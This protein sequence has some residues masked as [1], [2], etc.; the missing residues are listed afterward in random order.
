MLNRLET[1]RGRNPELG[2]TAVE[3]ALMVTMIAAVIIG[4]VAMI[5]TNLIPIFRNA[6]SSI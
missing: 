6:S 5:G 3:Y 2:A 4:A 1:L